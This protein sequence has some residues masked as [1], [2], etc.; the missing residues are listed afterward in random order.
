M[1]TAIDRSV[2]VRPCTREDREAWDAFVAR[3][4]SATSYQRWEWGEVIESTMGLPRLYL[5]AFR[6]GALCGVLPLVRQRLP[7]GGVYFTSL[8]FVNY[9]GVAALDA[10]AAGALLD[11]AAL[12]VRE[13]GAAHAE[14]RSVP[15]A[16]LPLPSTSR[17]VRPT[18]ALPAD[19]ETLFATFPSKQRSAVRKPTKEGITFDSG[20]AELLGEFYRVVSTRWR[21]LGSPIYRRAFFE[22]LWEAFPGEN[23]IL[24]VRRGSELVGAGWLHTW[25]GTA[26]M[27]WSAT[28]RSFDPAR[29]G[30]LLYWGAFCTAIERG[31]QVFD[32]GRSTEDSPTHRFKM[33]W[34][35]RIEPLPW[36][37][38][39]GHAA[40]P[41]APVED[42][43]KGRLFRAV[44]RSL[45]LPL[46][47]RLGQAVARGLP[48]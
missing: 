30:T 4:A 5:G 45:P 22:R 47:Q 11:S 38:V 24:R 29:P 19:P 39:L 6:D 46:T 37:Y 23:V 2:L 31:A 34:S 16:E 27:I 28:D 41:P 32:F 15:G 25:R 14:L 10:A 33:Q 20:G 42:N 44:W 1:T 35:P 26:E 40:A 3:C 8:P 36:H 43:W 18:L 12:A 17:K 9:A 21:A 7:L 48:L 13:A